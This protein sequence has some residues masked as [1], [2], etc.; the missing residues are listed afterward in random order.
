MVRTTFFVPVAPAPAAIAAALAL[1]A[2]A[3]GQSTP[4]NFKVAFLG[5][6]GLGADSEA[7]L[8]LCVSEGAD[9]ILILGDL[10]YNDDPA[11]WSAQ[12]QDRLGV[13]FPVFAVVGNHE[14]NE[15]EG[16]LD[17][18]QALLECNGVQWH[19]VAGDQYSFTWNGIYFVFSTPGLF[20]GPDAATY[21]AQRL[22]TP[23]AQ[24]AIWRISAFHVLQEAM[25]IGGKSDEAGWD[26]YENS[27]LG[28]AIVAT[29]HEHSYARTNLLSDM[30][31]QTVAGQD[32]VISEGETFAFHSGIGGSSIRDQ[33]R[34]FPETWP[35]G[36]NGTWASIYTTNQG[37]NHGALFIEFNFGGDPRQARGY[38]KDIDGNVPDEF[39]VHSSVGPSACV[40]DINGD[41]VV[42][43][44]DKQQVIDDWG[45]QGPC[46]GDVTGNLVVD[47]R[48]LLAV[49][50][51]W[52]ACPGGLGQVASAP[53]EPGA[54]DVIERV[55][56]PFWLADELLRSRLAAQAP[57]QPESPQ[58][59][60]GRGANR[61]DP[62]QRLADRMKKF[63]RAAPGS[64]GAGTVTSRV[65]HKPPQ[66]PGRA[67]GAAPGAPPPG[68]SDPPALVP[69]AGPRGNQA[70][71][72][73][74][75]PA[76]RER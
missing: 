39:F 62:G 76:G 7:V 2:A 28:G 3:S 58:A 44:A 17:A 6:Q 11:A 43:N 34:C 10:D 12:L 72:P 52:G 36:C 70:P 13:C 67:P 73:P 64:L 8:D 57:E 48:D 19:G 37:A 24:A 9:A 69:N 16:Y 31:S 66:R 26:V 33:E 46:P 61:H 1:A 74:A 20:G 54:G 71:P 23:E 56:D 40:C 35:Y 22:A 60:P 53:K 32:L 47:I 65:T 75:Q 49:L 25:Q 30:S 38:F 4:V 59:Q 15:Y 68:P 5:D 42:N 14:D 18:I 21:V 45:C 50:A 41:A 27:R 63:R 51:N 55:R 29:A